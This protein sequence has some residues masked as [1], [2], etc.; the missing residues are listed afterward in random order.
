MRLGNQSSRQPSTT[1]EIITNLR[2]VVTMDA[3]RIHKITT[4]FKISQILFFFDLVYLAILMANWPNQ[5][6]KEGNR[7]HRL[8]IYHDMYIQ[9]LISLE[10]YNSRETTNQ[11]D[12]KQTASF[13]H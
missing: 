12:K 9:N 2:T 6:L 3:G 1:T 5:Y 7:R 8:I 4:E 13:R 11:G 10:Y